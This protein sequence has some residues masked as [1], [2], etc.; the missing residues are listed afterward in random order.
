MNVKIVFNDKK[1]KEFLDNINLETPFFIEYIDI[2]SKKG[3]KEGWKLMNYYG[4]N[5][6]PF[7]EIDNEIPFY[8]EKGNAVFQL[9]NYLNNDCKN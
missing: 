6:F 5:K 4:T 1:D 9:I 7:V 2:N 8:S 3:K